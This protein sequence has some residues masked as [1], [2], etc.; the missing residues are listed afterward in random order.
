MRLGKKQMMLDDECD[1]L[2]T[3]SLDGDH[4]C[5]RVCKGGSPILFIPPLA[6]QSPPSTGVQ[7]RMLDKW[8]LG[9]PQARTTTCVFETFDR[10]G[11]GAE[12]SIVNNNAVLLRL[13]GI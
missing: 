13:V 10:M 1:F 11:E 4:E 2:L 9:A 3:A 5:W 8:A 7:G 6:F 12:V